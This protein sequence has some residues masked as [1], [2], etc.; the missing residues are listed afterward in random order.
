MLF[1]N[2]ISQFIG[3]EKN[4]KCKQIPNTWYEYHMLF[5]GYREPFLTPVV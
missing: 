1:S 2:R 5:V 3:K 4:L